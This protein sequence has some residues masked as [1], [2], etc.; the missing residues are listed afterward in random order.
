MIC[1]RD[2]TTGGS[3]LY[4]LDP[5]LGVN[6]I[7]STLTF[8]I[9]FTYSGGTGTWVAARSGGVATNIGFALYGN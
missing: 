3:A 2:N 1:I 4:L 5:N 6:L 8:T 7:A 9:T